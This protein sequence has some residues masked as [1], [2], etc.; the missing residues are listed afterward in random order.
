MRELSEKEILDHVAQVAENGYSIMEN[1]IQ[2]DYIKEILQE[3]ERLEEVR[4]L[5]IWETCLAKIKRIG[6]IA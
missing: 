4:P 5:E 3:L 1:A 2:Q 6:K